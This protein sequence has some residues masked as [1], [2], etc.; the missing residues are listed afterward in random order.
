[1]IVVGALLLVAAGLYLIGTGSFTGHWGPGEPEGAAMPAAVVEARGKAQVVAAEAAGVPDAR[2]I[3]FGDFH[4]HTTFSTDAFLMALPMTG[5]DGAYPVADACDFA[6]YCAALDFWSI[7]DHAESL[8]PRQWRETVE[9]IRQCDAIS[10]DPVNPDVVPFLGW[11]WTQMGTVPDNHYGHKNVVLRH[12]DDERIPARP[13][14][15]AGPGTQDAMQISPFVLSLLALTGA[16]RQ[17]FDL[18]RYL[19][20]LTDVSTCPR[21][22]PVRELP[23]DCRELVVTPGELFAKLNEWD[24]E[25][26]VI[27]HGTTWG[28]YTP[29]GASWDKQ[30]DPALHDPKRQTLMEVYSGHG[31]SEEFRSWREVIYEAD[32]SKRCPEPTPSF[33]PSCW[34]AGEII[35]A[36]C[37]TEGEEP[38]VCEARADEARRLYLDGGAGGHRVV[39]GARVE[40]WL[41]SGQCRDCFQP[42]FNYRPRSSVQYILALSKFLPGKA[43]L[44]FRFGFLASSDSHSARPGT[45]YKEYARTEM[46][47]SRFENFLGTV[48]GRVEERE[49]TSVPEPVDWEDRIGNIFSFMETERGS[50]FFLTG[51]LVAVHASGRSRDAIWEALQRRE[52]YGT[53]GPRILLWFDLLN[54]PGSRGR[55]DPMGSE[56]TMRDNPIFQVRAVGSLE[57]QPGCPDWAHEGLSAERLERL[58]RGDCYNP[59]TQRRR[60]ARI[61]VVRIRPQASTG[62]PVEKLIQDPWKVLDC[63]P[64]PVGC[65]V[66]FFDG[67]FASAGRDTLY[68]VRAIEETSPAINADGLRCQR[69]AEGNCLKVD[70]CLSKPADDDCLAETQQRAWSSP[71]YLNH[72]SSG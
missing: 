41:D 11:E 23:G 12:L 9:A 63:Q 39:P 22:V 24:H 66:T 54:P 61:E 52:V 56:V 48:L 59:S 55:P 71:I 25:S 36:R 17:S 2:Q 26:I 6:R 19:Y 46:T 62:E 4:A 28:L 70:P 68:Y 49:P 13:I 1:L 7:N 57:Q 51:G 3:L 42:S 16:D 32:G 72:G 58:C 31:N 29:L 34:Q 35:K 38:D 37:Q 60:I 10:G 65:V 69:D 5:G 40:D 27:P 64:D 18:T 53:S 8:T 50:S 33:L 21:D 15:S 44:R 14:G 30:L 47:E 20:E 43:P 45:G 67:D